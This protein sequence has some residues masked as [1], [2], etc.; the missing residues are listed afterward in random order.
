[1]KRRNFQGVIVLMNT[2]PLKERT[3]TKIFNEK[4]K[5]LM[6][7][8]PH[9]NMTEEGGSSSQKSI[10][11]N[12]KALLINSI[13]KIFPIIALWEKKIIKVIITTVVRNIT[14]DPNLSREREKRKDG[15]VVITT[16][17][18]KIRIMRI[19]VDYL[20]RLHG[21]PMR[22]TMT[23]IFMVGRAIM[24]GGII[25]KNT[26]NTRIAKTGKAMNTGLTATSIRTT[27]TSTT[28]F[29]LGT[30]ITSGNRIHIM[31]GVTDTEITMD[32]N[33]RPHIGIRTNN[34]GMG[35]G[36]GDIIQNGHNDLTITSQQVTSGTSFTITTM[37][38]VI[39]INP[40]P[41]HTQERCPRFCH[42]RA[43]YGK[44]SLMILIEG[45]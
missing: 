33:Q 41:L 17:I 23:T 10:T 43:Q 11:E 5:A 31:T 7:I 21:H 29:G 24:K 37:I 14:N 13:I 26:A 12:L 42:P 9:L 44:N 3:M 6:I 27:V 32:G 34:R 1:M 38:I 20:T 30:R 25:A 45:L 22:I 16:T 39:E 36:H 4:K 40:D 2:D 35:P 28:G 8:L 15:R 19:Q 18:M